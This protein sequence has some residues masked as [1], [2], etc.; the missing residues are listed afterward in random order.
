MLHSGQS[1]NEAVEKIPDAL[2]GVNMGVRLP[3]PT[4]DRGV[5]A[6]LRGQIIHGNPNVF[7]KG[8]SFS[9]NI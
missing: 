2:N 6:I 7:K 3:F 1:F 9:L 4:G 5:Y 8:F